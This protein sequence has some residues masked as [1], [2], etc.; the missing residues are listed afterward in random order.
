MKILQLSHKMPFPLHDGGACSICN[1]AVGL[2]NRGMDVTVFAITTPRRK[3][4]QEEVPAEYSARTRFSCCEVDT[5]IK[6]VAAFLNLF[7]HESYFVERFWSDAWNAGLE[8][9][10]AH[11]KFDIIQ[12]EHIY[13]CLY[14]ETIRKHSNAKVIL[15]PQ[16]V[17]NQVWSR[18]IA[19]EK[20]PLKRQYL[21]I[22]TE[23]LKR[24]EMKAAAKVDGIIAI[25]DADAA[26]FRTY[27]PGM[28]IISVP[29]GFDFSRVMNYNLQQGYDD[30]PAFYHLGSMDWMPNIQGMRW[31]VDEVVPYIRKEYPGFRFRMAGKNMPQWFMERQD[32]NI[33]ADR[34]V[35]DS[36]DYQR[37]KAVMIVPLLSGGGLRAKIIEGMA[38]GKTIISTSVGAEGIPYTDGENLLIA[39]TKEEF[40]MQV[41]KCRDSR[42][43]CLKIGENARMLALE[44]F[45]CNAL[46]G[47]MI[48]FYHEI[49]GNQG[50]SDNN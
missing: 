18:C 8:R 45:D 4:H 7:S 43:M 28:N 25:S 1:T 23:R 35:S 16:N 12:L 46:A 32:E 10:L 27:A 11:E 30:F 38:L 39:N 31:F 6:P 24:F 22:A 26:V 21:R 34:M 47:K 44:Y 36:L 50:I 42:E 48:A 9:I 5:R 3:A 19:C 17:E 13:L 20:N 37:D 15:R 33:I 49:L 29:L 40:A 14:L 41:A 2:M